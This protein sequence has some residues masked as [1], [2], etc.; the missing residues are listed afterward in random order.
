MTRLVLVAGTTETA[1]IDGISAAG[2]SPALRARTPSADA[3][4]VC[5]G[6]PIGGGPVPVSPAGCVTPAV[7]TRAARTLVGFDVTVVDA[8]LSTPTA[9]PHV[10]MDAAPGGK[11][12]G[13]TPVPDAAAVLDRGRQFGRALPDDRLVVGETIPGG[14]TTALGVLS[15]LGEPATVSSSMRNNPI[16]RKRSIVEAGETASGLE[17]GAAAGQPVR[18]LRRMGDPVLAAAT[19]IV[20]GALSSGTEVILGGGTQLIAVAALVRELGRA[21]PMTLATTAY[22]AGDPTVDL[23]DMATAQELSLRVTDPGFDRVEDPAMAR[24][25]DGEGKEGVGMGGTLAMLADADIEFAALRR[26]V[27]ALGDRLTADEPSAT[28][29]APGDR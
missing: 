25:A 19:G 7:V 3:E 15:A 1:A 9:A 13:P 18:A 2:A 29:T 26:T 4:I 5:Y 21:A 24:Y 27:G 12:T 16:E 8:G 22:V 20:V 10:S 23:E 6:L 11:I 17:S 28:F 14:T